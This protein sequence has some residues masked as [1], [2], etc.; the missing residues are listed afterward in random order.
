MPNIFT[1]FY[2]VMM[3]VGFGVVLPKLL[4]RN[5]AQYT[6][7][8]QAKVVGSSRKLETVQSIDETHGTYTRDV[9]RYRYILNYEYQGR[10]YTEESLQ[11][12]FFK[13]L[14]GSTKKIKINPNEPNR[15]VFETSTEKLFKL[16]GLFMIIISII[17]LFK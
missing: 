1:A 2:G 12:V 17:F 14:V 16:A 11:S 10:S 5:N 15:F 7:P 6:V 13:P 8:V 9:Y 3:G 4:N